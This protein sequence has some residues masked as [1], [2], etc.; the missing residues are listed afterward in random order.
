VLDLGCGK[1]GT[2]AWLL[3]QGFDAYGIDTRAEYIENGR[4]YLDPDRLTVLDGD[5]YPYPNDY[6][7]IVISDQ[8]FEHVADLEQLAREVTRTTKPGGVGL[9]VFPAKWMFVEPHMRTPLVHWLPKGPVRH[10]AIRTA[11]S[12]GW[13]APYFNDR[14]IADRAVIYSKYSDN[15]TFYRRLALIGQVLEAAGLAV[16]WRNESRT[17]V[18]GKLGNPNWPVPFDLIAAWAYRHVRIVCLTT[19]R[20]C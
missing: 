7:D 2:V 10:A 1:G 19:V 3:E 16:D 14:N 13:A 15:E 11:L 5:S 20:G 6:F 18:R 9:H 17:V 8:V 12:L 4:C